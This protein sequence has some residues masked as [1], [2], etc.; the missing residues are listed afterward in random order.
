MP[1][2]DEWFARRRRSI[3]VAW[4]IVLSSIALFFLGVS[5][6]ESQGWA[7]FVL[8][9]SIFVF[10]GGLIYG[11]VAVRL[12]TAQRISDEYVWLKGVHPRFL[13]RLEIWPYNV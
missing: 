12:V 13:D 2:S 7:P 4:G 3:V 5:T 6:V 10:L 8:I 11:L 9:A 1:L